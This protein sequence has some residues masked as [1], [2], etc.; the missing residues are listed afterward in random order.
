MKMSKRL[1]VTVLAASILLAGC[2]RA[3]FQS[4]GVSA[5]PVS[6]SDAEKLD[7]RLE[8]L[9]AQH[10]L[11]DEDRKR[12]KSDVLAIARTRDRLSLRDVGESCGVELQRFCR[13]GV[14]DSAKLVCIKAN[15]DRVSD[16]CEAEL[17]KQFGSKPTEVA[18]HYLGV[19]I[20]KGSVYR[21][22]H[23]DQ[24]S[25]VILSDDVVF[26]GIR[27]KKGA[28]G[29][30]KSGISVARLT[31]NQTI[32]GIEYL[33]S[34]LG[35]FFN[36]SG[37]VVNATLARDTEIDGIVYMAGQQITFHSKGRVNSG[38]VA[39]AV[40]V[41]GASY[42][43]GDMIYFDRKGAVRDLNKLNLF[44]AE[45]EPEPVTVAKDYIGRTF[46]TT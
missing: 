29:F 12:L 40:R 11:T 26:K 30:H 24:V 17:R 14:G 6:E 45:P 43:P 46:A 19:P 25:S 4:S 5:E 41:Q 20:P 10:G 13:N 28:I 44:N 34:G 22:N 39:R 3:G 21:Y 1:A 2:T 15:R 33:A 23:L 8:V 9:S 7:K 38:R 16:V 31:S 42:S 27:F 18:Q 36:E 32:G 37:A 35:P